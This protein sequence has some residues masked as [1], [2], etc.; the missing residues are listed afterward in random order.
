MS[1]ESGLIIGFVADFMF[2][3]RIENVARS[4]GFVLQL[5]GRADEIAPMDPDAPTYQPGEPL[6]GQGGDLFK[7][8]TEWQPALII[9]D[10]G[11][12]LIPWEKWI[13]TLKSSPATRRFPILCYGPHVDTQK[14]TRAREI[15]ADEVVARSRFTS[16]M[17]DLF[18]RLALRPDTSG[19]SAAC[20]EPLSTK[21]LAGIDHFNH[22]RFYDAHH[23]LEDAWVEDQGP[24][25]DLYRAIL[26]IGV[27]Y[28]QIERGN[29]RG[30]VKM[31]LRVRQWLAPL[32]DICRSVN[33]ARLREDVDNVY[34]TLQ[35]LGADRV[36]ELD[37]TLFRPVERLT[38]SI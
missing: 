33:V 22:G 3:V 1:D 8:V 7:K 5:I 24:G 4:S 20:A 34:T 10:L 26:Q 12:D 13:A 31:L 32:P 2:S 28:Y 30:A 18:A 35:E 17:P 29:Y 27:A 19:I 23:G 14:L 11:N 6:F 37:R 15:G 25:R 36:T 38:T 21:A 9:F 16:A